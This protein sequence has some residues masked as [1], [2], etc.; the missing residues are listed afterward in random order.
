M[1]LV[2]NRADIHIID[3][4]MLMKNFPHLDSSRTCWLQGVQSTAENH[5]FLK[6]WQVFWWLMSILLNITVARSLSSE[7]ILLSSRVWSTASHWCY[8]HWD[9]LCLRCQEADSNLYSNNLEL[10]VKRSVNSLQEVGHSL[11]IRKVLVSYQ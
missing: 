4:P 11:H 2:S 1:S 9:A 7:S 10:I 6:M 3:V 5:T 8:H